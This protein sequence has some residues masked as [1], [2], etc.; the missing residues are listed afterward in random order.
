[1]DYKTQMPSPKTTRINQTVCVICRSE[2]NKMFDYH[3]FNYFRCP[4]CRHVMTLPYPTNLQLQEHYDQA[5]EDG[6]YNTARKHEDVY[7]SAMN[8][9]VKLIKMHFDKQGRSLNNLTALDVGCFTGEFLYCM[10]QQGAD[11][12]GIEYQQQAAKIA[13][14]KLPGRIVNADVLND[15]FS[16]PLPEFDVITLFGVVEHVIDPVG[17]IERMVPLLKKNG[18]LMIQTPNSSSML[19]RLMGKYWL[20]Y[21]PVEHIHLFS[22]KSLEK[23]LRRNMFE[24]IIFKAHWKTLSIA[25]A[26][27]MLKTF[28]PKFYR[29]SKSF[30]DILPKFI[31]E[32]RMPFYIGEVILFASIQK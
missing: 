6:N 4:T 13:N 23:T 31:T 17:L 7:M 25:Y 12:Y 30:F 29:I 3:S 27:S 32:I 28:G 16:L 24:N 9:F 8:K 21:T 5:F 22:T 14:Q 26:H 19:A 18:L 10:H 15:S 20:P 1:M 2:M 11:V